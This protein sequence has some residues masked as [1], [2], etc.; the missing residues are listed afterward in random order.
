[1][2]MRGTGKTKR[3]ADQKKARMIPLKNKMGAKTK[4]ERDLRAAM[5][6]LK[7]IALRATPRRSQE[8]RERGQAKGVERE[9]VDRM[10]THGAKRS[11]P[12]ARQVRGEAVTG[13]HKM[14]H[15]D[16]L[17]PPPLNRIKNLRG[18]QTPQAV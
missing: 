17:N 2:E 9:V 5:E 6:I 14:P 15:P 3:A 18:A 10:V 16:L 4:R 13:R 12:K 7:A 1:M 8:R 11:H